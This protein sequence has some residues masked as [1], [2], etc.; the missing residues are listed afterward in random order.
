MKA[1]TDRVCNLTL[2]Y[3]HAREALL[4]QHRAIFDAIQR[5]DPD[6]AEALIRDH[7][8]SILVD[9]AAVEVEHADLFER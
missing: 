9:L 7:L 5:H 2:E 4:V 6:A 8:K 3:P 1:H